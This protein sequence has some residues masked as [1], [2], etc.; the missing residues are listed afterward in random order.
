MSEA[1]K[2]EVKA[3]AHN[4]LDTLKREKFVLDWRKQQ[5]SRAAVK[6][7]IEIALDELPECYTQELYDGKCEV[8]YQHVYDS[9]YGLG[10]SVFAM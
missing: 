7:A 4:L 10:G 2:N 6:L 1:E 9:Y 5:Q 3:I 8:I